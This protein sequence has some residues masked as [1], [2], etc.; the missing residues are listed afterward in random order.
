MDH[1]I[2]RNG[3]KPSMDQL[4][5][6]FTLSKPAQSM[7]EEWIDLGEFIRCLIYF[8]A[9]LFSDQPDAK[10]EGLPFEE[11]LELV[12]KWCHKKHAQNKVLPKFFR[13]G[14]LSRIKERKLRRMSS[15]FTKTRP[16]SNSMHMNYASANVA[17]TIPVMRPHSMHMSY[18]S[19]NAVRGLV[20]AN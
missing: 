4:I 2:W 17:D 10:Y 8:T 5:Q 1:G 9:A 6:C 15:K 3:G 14:S 20:K 12:L 16:H 13:T 7:D 11:K 18:A 19:A